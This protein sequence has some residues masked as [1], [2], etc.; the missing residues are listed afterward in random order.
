MFAN[1]HHDDGHIAVWIPAPPGVQAMLIETSP[2]TFFRPPYVGVRGWIGIELDR[3]SDEDL[4]AHIREARGLVG[5]KT[6]KRP[7]R[8]SRPRR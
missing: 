5:P 1:N 7:L 3:I 6:A 4:A 2:E 8:A